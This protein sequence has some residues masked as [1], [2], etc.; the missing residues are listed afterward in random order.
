MTTK[1]VTSTPLAHV[2]EEVPDDGTPYTVVASTTFQKKMGETPGTIGHTDL[3]LDDYEDGEWH[4]FRQHSDGWTFIDEM[5]GRPYEPDIRENYG[6]GKYK[7]IPVDKNGKQ[8]IKF[9]QVLNVGSAISRAGDEEAPPVD[10]DETERESDSDRHWRDAEM[11]AWMRYQLQQ[12]AE[13]RTEAKRSQQS[14]ETKREEWERLQAQREWERQEREERYRRE[15][16]VAEQKEREE[17]REREGRERQE[18]LERDQREREFKNQQMTQVMGAATTVITAFL[19]NRHA[20]QGDGAVNDKML[21]YLLSARSNSNSGMSMR[22]QIEMLALL[23]SLRESKSAPEKEPDMLQNVLKLAPLLS[24]FTKGGGGEQPSPEQLAAVQ[25]ALQQ[26]QQQQQPTQ[27]APSAA[28]GPP[29][30]GQAAA[31]LSNPEAVAQAAM[32][33]PDGI[34]K[35][36]VAAVKGN[37]VL[38]GAVIKA[39]EE[40]EN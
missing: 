17:R 16:M 35:S 20:P 29:D 5:T 8:A 11:P 34:A 22:D 23:D 4:I 40:E 7:A 26:Q 32:Q 18:R 6:E 12:A 13:E 24:L 2:P 28:F 39:L 9:S 27:Q 36:V 21:G 33:D 15:T 25:Q 3:V 31:V 19:E 1:R 30:P 14:S 37:P 10:F 38:E